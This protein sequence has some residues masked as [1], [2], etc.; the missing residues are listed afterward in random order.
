MGKRQIGEL[1]LSELVTTILLS[2]LASQPIT[3][4]QIP[5]AF[6]VIPIAVLLSLEVIISFAVTKVPFLKPIF[7]GK[8]SI[9]ISHGVIDKAEVAKVRIS[10]EELLSSL[11]IEGIGDISEVDYAILEHNGQLSVIPKRA[12]SPPTADDLKTKITE[13][14]IA[15]AVIVDGHISD[16]DLQ[17]IGHDREWLKKRL[18]H[19]KTDLKRVYLFTVNDD[20]KEYLVKK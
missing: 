16:F 4:S 15:H 2:E 3:D 12:A 20:G 18:A 19:Y 10:L 14:G 7:D 1:Q 9:L 8:P 13:S 17:L 6:A 11:R 5:F